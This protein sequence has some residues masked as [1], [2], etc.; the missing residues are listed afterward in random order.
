M[1]NAEFRND[2]QEKMKRSNS[3]SLE[4]PIPGIA[5]LESITDRIDELNNQ[6]KTIGQTRFKILQNID[7]LRN[8]QKN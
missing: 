4:V 7:H 1:H 5:T 6:V 3:L 2:K 8:M